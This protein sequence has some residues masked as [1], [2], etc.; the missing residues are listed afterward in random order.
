M[1]WRSA[2]V[3]SQGMFLQPHHFQQE[4]RFV[5]HLVDTRVRAAE[6]YAWGFAEL[7]IDEAQLAL[8]RMAL[9]RAS[10]VLTDGTPFSASIPRTARPSAHCAAFAASKPIACVSTIASRNPTIASVGIVA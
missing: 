2:V 7:V 3:W 1:S 8:G 9:A 4:A 5:E 6:P 10:G